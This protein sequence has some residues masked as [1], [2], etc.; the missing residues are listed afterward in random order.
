[1]KIFDSKLQGLAEFVPLERGKVAI[2]VCG[3]TVQ[4]APHI[5]HLRS[6][7]AFDIVARWLRIGHGYDVT[8]VRNVTDIDD[9]IL[10]NAAEQNKDWRELA[11]EVE[12]GF[13]AVYDS[14]GAS[15]N[16]SPHATE[17]IN[18][19]I[20]LIKRLI[21][22]GHA[23]QAENG[24]ANVFFDTA[25][26]PGYGELTNQKLE[27]LEGEAIGGGRRAPHD[28]AL[29]KSAKPGEPESAAWDS[30]WGKGR[31]GWHIEC[32]AMTLSAL[33]ESFDIHGGGLDLRFP[34]HENELAQSRAAGYEFA[35]HWMHNGLVTVSGTKRSYSHKVAPPQCATG[36]L[37]LTTDPRSTTRQTQC[38]KPLPRCLESPTLPEGR[39]KSRVPPTLNFLPN[40]LKPWIQTSTCPLL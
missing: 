16:Q 32:S 37:R 1:M 30:P 15:V 7:V 5:G 12:A 14:L 29:W 38:L 4:S 2:Y 36:W 35:K 10:V 27:N 40:S 13:N 34:H 39:A 24:M 6:A 20:S 8:L 11:S 18:D 28:F 23:Y 19:M 31:P 3:P 17:H 33:G 26:D 21:E 9:K 22:R 25:S